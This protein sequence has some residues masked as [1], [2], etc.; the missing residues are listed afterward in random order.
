MFSFTSTVQD[1]CAPV[2]VDFTG[3]VDDPV[4]QLDFKWSFGDGATDS[5][6]EVSHT[7][8]VPNNIY[9]VGLKA[10]SSITGCSD[11]IREEGYIT[12][13]PVPK[14][15]FTM[16]HD[17]VYNDMPQV[18]FSDQST[19]AVNYLWDFGDGTHSREK[20]PIHSYAVVGKRK[21]L[22][23]VY[24]QFDCQDTISGNVLVAFNRI[25][26]PNAFS[27]NASNAIDRVFLLASE[28]IRQDGYHL[29]ILSRWSDIVFECKNVVKAWD[30]KMTNGNFAPAGNYIWI[31]ECFDFLGRPHRQS[32]SLTLLF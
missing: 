18:S 29:T 27:P 4:D 10:I 12:V 1:G 5:G 14:A 2:P 22:Q 31:L 8:G 21:V 24:N 9:A 28:G 13:H 23:T 19:N 17:I 20:D 32:G 25:F 7:Y 15:G 3:K 11:S 30:G 6:A 16:D 26:A